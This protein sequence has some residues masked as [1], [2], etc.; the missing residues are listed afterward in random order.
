M[1]AFPKQDAEPWEENPVTAGDLLGYAEQDPMNIIR[2]AQGI[3]EDVPVEPLEPITRESGMAQIVGDNII[4]PESYEIEDEESWEAQAAEWEPEDRN[5]HSG[6]LMSY[7]VIE[8]F[9]RCEEEIPWLERQPKWFQASLLKL[10][11]FKDLKQ[12]GAWSRVIHKNGGFAG[13]KFNKDQAGV[14]WSEYYNK[15]AKLTPSFL[16][17]ACR[18]ILER[19]VKA[20]GQL[21]YFGKWL[22]KVQTGQIKLKHP[23]TEYEFGIIWDTY[24]RRKEVQANA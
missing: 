20:N 3:C 24:K 14:F 8:D 16:S 6:N 23:P 18:S 4:W 12:L 17:V 9:G 13:R 5:P 22:Y 19:I 1:R 15:K 7:H 10:Q 2:G 21:G 11:S